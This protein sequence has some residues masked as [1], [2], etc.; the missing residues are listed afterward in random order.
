MPGLVR[1]CFGLVCRG[2]MVTDVWVLGGFFFNG[3]ALTIDNVDNFGGWLGKSSF[4][5]CI[6]VL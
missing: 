4:V 6:L 5:S 2:S 1:V 3:T